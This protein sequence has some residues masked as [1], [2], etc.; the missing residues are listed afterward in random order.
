MARGL[1]WGCE[2]TQV[3]CWNPV[4]YL[5]KSFDVYSLDFPLSLLDEGRRTYNL[6]YNTRHRSRV[7]F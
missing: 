3:S 1:E 6:H 7:G 4:R 5:A 2:I